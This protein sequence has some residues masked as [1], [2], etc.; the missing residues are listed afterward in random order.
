MTLKQE[1][2]MDDDEVTW[3]GDESTNPPHEPAETPET[4]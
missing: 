4:L 1:R 2:K 3:S